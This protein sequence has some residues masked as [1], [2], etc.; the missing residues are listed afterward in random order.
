MMIYFSSAKDIELRF[1]FSSTA[2]DR[3]ISLVA[4]CSGTCKMHVTCVYLCAGARLR[5]LFP[6]L[7]HSLS[8]PKEAIFSEI[9]SKAN[10]PTVAQYH[11][12]KYFPFLYATTDLISRRQ[13][14]SIVKKQCKKKTTIKPAI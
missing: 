11:I 13:R 3:G 2:S 9:L 5:K 12:D 14:V 8:L 1:P 4:F 10:A 7:F 6:V